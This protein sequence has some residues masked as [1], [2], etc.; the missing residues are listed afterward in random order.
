[1]VTEGLKS[2]GSR[3][4]KENL[5]STLGVRERWGCHGV[6]WFWAISSDFYQFSFAELKVVNQKQY[7]AFSH[8]NN[9]FF[10]LWCYLHWR[11]K[12]FLIYKSHIF[13]FGS[14]SCLSSV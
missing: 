3:N 12:L 5:S 13:S 4:I 7:S 10:S 9:I 6:R 14:Q 11:E 8:V 1:M 2:S